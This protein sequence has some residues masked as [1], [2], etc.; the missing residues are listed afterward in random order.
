MPAGEM[1]R[2]MW[3]KCLQ[4]S[5]WWGSLGSWRRWVSYQTQAIWTSGDIA[6]RFARQSGWAW[7]DRLLQLVL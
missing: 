5:F 4:A 1:R 2:L 3:W 6:T 7:T